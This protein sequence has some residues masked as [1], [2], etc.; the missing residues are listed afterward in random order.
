MLRLILLGVGLVWAQTS[1]GDDYEVGMA[2]RYCEYCLVSYCI[3]MGGHGVP[4]WD[5]PACTKYFPNVNSDNVTVFK[6]HFIDRSIHAFVAYEPTMPEIIIGFEGTDPLNLEEWIDDIEYHKIDYPLS[7]CNDTDCQVHRGFWDTYNEIREDL[8][9]TVEEYI[10]YFGS[11]VKVHITGHSLGS[12][13]AT[14]CA[15]DGALNYKQNYDYVYTFGPPRVGD[16]NFAA[17]YETLV[18]YHYRVT[19]HKDPV[20]QLPEEWQDKGFHHISHEVYYE[21]D[22]N[23]TYKVCDGSGEDPTC[24]D[25]YDLDLVHIDDHLDYMGFDFT[26]NM[27][28]CKV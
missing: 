23:S 11:D 28:E 18:P 24:R 25:Q 5:C 2:C 22:P 15:L 1:L 16:K 10:D 17:F 13:L 20:P 27:I 6:T 8:W 7:N 26:T 21:N 4:K 9:E 19:H 3:G 12:A 14:H